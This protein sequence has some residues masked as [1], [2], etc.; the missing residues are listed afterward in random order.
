MT[1]FVVSKLPAQDRLTSWPRTKKTLVQD[2]LY[3]TL[4]DTSIFDKISKYASTVKAFSIVL[5]DM[6]HNMSLPI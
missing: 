4:P 2:P 6:F 1:L 5:E 3:T